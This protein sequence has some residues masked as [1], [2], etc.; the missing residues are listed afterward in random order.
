MTEADRRLLNIQTVY[1]ENNPSRP[2]TSSLRVLPSPPV[3]RAAHTSLS[4]VD[5]PLLEVLV[6]R[7]TLKFKSLGH[8]SPNPD[9]IVQSMVSVLAF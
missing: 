5:S 4:F 6:Q 2:H 7:V 1:K 3:P 8:G 9:K